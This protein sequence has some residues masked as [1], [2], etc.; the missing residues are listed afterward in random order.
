M[1]VLFDDLIDVFE[2]EKTVQR[3]N[4]SIMKM[5]AGLTWLD[6]IVHPIQ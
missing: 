6:E 4:K 1:T 3:S 5:C 2:Y